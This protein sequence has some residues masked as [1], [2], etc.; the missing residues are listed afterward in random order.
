MWTDANM[1]SLS[2]A[3]HSSRHTLWVKLSMSSWDFN[4]CILSVDYICFYVFGIDKIEDYFIM[5]YT[6][7]LM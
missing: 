7:V 3:T 1:V 2:P 6:H 4:P 5:S